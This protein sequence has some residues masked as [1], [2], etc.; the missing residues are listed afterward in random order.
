MPQPIIF[1]VVPSFIQCAS[2]LSFFSLRTIAFHFGKISNEIRYCRCSLVRRLQ[3]A[4]PTM[5]KKKKL[6][7][8]VGATCTILTRFMHP[9]VNL[10]DQNHRTTVVLIEKEEKKVNRRQQQCFTFRCLD[11][12]LLNHVCYSVKS[13]LNVI[14]EGD[15]AGFFHPEDVAAAEH[16][17]EQAN[18]IEPKIK[19]R[20]SQ[21]KQLL[22]DAIVDGR[23]PEDD[24]GDELMGLEEIYFL[25]PAFSLYSYEKFHDRLARVRAE[26]KHNKNRAVEDLNAFQ[27][28]M[29]NHE[30]SY[31]SHKGYIQWQGSNAQ[32]LLL[33]DMLNGLHIGM[34][35]KT[36]WESRSE[37]YEQ[38]PLGAFRDKIKQE[39]R[40]AKY[41][42][43]CKAKGIK[44]KAS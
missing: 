20:K 22:H 3:S 34:K 25:L 33:D 16:R 8:G 23:I 32:D 11:G 4:L 17:D 28:Y 29:R 2:D 24:N 18:F 15:R 37:Y 27:I 31:F 9:R 5:T 30:V 13:H 44:Y 40:T 41:L 36:L 21:A 39:I 6:Y 12:P 26:I 19:W 7:P 38:F 14:E 43:T 1:P 35:P 10:D 42:H